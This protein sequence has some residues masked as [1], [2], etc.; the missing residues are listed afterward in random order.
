MNPAVMM[1]LKQDFW[2]IL[3]QMTYLAFGRLDLCGKINI[4]SQ[5]LTERNIIRDLIE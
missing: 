3:D 2:S 1:A 5:D 4:K